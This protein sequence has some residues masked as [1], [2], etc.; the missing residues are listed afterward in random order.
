MTSTLSKIAE[1]FVIDHELKPKILQKIDPH[2]FGFIPKSCTTHAI[3][4]MLHSWLAA[5]DGTGSTVKVALLDFR[6]AFDLVDHNLL[7]TKLI[8]YGIKPSVTNWITDFLRKRTQRIKLNY[9]CHSNVLQDQAGVPQGTKLAPWLFLIM[10][11]DLSVSENSTNKM[12]KF[13]DDSTISEVIPRTEKSNLQDIVDQLLYNWSNNNK[14]QLNSGKC[15]EIRINFTKDLCRDE[16]VKVN[17]KHFEVVTSAKILGMTITDDLKWNVHVANILL[18]ASKRLYL[19]KQLKRANV[20]T[21]SL[22][23]FYCACIR[24]VLEYACQAFH[25]GLPNYLS[26]EIEQIQKRALRIIYPYVDYREALEMGN[27]ERLN[28]REKLCEK[29]FREI[30]ENEDH[31][32]HG[33]LPERIRLFIPSEQLGNIISQRLGQIDLRILLSLITHHER[34]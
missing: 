16:P 24:S 2:Q 19:L 27:L 23:K 31:K 18:K 25:S 14:F 22:N 28:R 9:K 4:S 21:N 17:D 32:L 34:K 1:G 6:K 26:K 30:E 29:L 20:D 11:N 5:T 3:I 8:N 33:L 10:I 13:A 7:I 12:W 15:K